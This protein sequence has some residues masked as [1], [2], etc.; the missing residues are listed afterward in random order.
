MEGA[1]IIYIG[2]DECEL[3]KDPVHRIP[4]G[5]K[6]KE[7]INVLDTV[8]AEGYVAPFRVNKF[9][10]KKYEI[11]KMV[12]KAINTHK[13]D[14]ILIPFPSFNQ[15]HKVVHEACMIALR[16]HDKNHFVKRVLVYNGSEYKLWGPQM[17]ETYFRVVNV[18]KK[19][20]SYYKYKSQRRGHRSF[21][22]LLNQHKITACKANSPSKYMEG[23]E[24]VRWVE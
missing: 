5:G 8:H 19:M 2:I 9:Y 12:E 11:V 24:V 10:E 22:L 7:M 15:D 23:F 21:G 1:T 14:T 3:P 20:I 18:P 13:P 4:I 17:N 16:P 6:K